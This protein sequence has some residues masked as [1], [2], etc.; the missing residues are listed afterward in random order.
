M[1]DRIKE[2]RRVRAA[3]IVGV[4][5]NWRTH[6]TS[7]LDA[8]AASIE[9]LGFFDPL[10]VRELP[11][12]K[13]Q[14]VNG[15]ARHELLSTRIGPDTIVPCVVTDFTEEEARRAILLQDPLSALASTDGAKLDALLA[16]VKNLPAA[17]DSYL[18]VQAEGAHVAELAGVDSEPVIEGLRSNRPEM[19]RLILPCADTAVFEKAMAATGLVNRAAALKAICE[20][21]LKAQADA[22]TRQQELRAEGPAP[23]VPP[24][25][26]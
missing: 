9:E 23:P 3:D 17:V 6:P 18:A 2:L 22:Q 21:Y 13:Y 8:L 4:D 10:H 26:T 20:T 19:V 24:C 16:E 25:G 1:R 14:I 5:W 11:A 12:G 15:H 7:Q